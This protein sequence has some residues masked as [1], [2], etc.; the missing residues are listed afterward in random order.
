MQWTKEAD[1]KLRLLYKT[2]PPLT[3]VEIATKLGTTA[4]AVAVRA[5]RLKIKKGQPNA[6]P[7]TDEQKRWLRLNFPHM[8]T[9]IC[10]LML[11][12]SNRTCVRRARELG[13]QKTPQFMKEAQAHTAKKAKESHLK[14]GTYRP[15]GYIIPGSEK[16]RFKPGHASTRKQKTLPQ[17]NE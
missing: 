9:E 5:S 6:K 11:G 1:E 7:L 3:R 4:Q 13:L 15:K 12:I 17:N 2:T 14:N 10:A 16:Y 8:A